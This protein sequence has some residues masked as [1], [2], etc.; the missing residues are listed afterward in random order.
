[1]VATQALYASGKKQTYASVDIAWLKNKVIK[2]RY[3][4]CSSPLC[5][6]QSCVVL[7]LTDCHFFAP[8]PK[9]QC[10]FMTGAHQGISVESGALW[11]YSEESDDPLHPCT[12]IRRGSTSSF[13]QDYGL[14]TILCGPTNTQN[15]PFVAVSAVRSVIK[16]LCCGSHKY[17]QTHVYQS[18][19][20]QACSG[21]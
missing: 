3:R 6:S 13:T 16:D 11:V 9:P 18:A 7:V 20:V 5:L 15:H 10:C 2:R 4:S 21:C 14:N 19:V 8:P 1:M 12:I 17:T